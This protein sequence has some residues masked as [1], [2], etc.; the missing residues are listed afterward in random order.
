MNS[1]VAIVGLGDMG[2]LY[3]S[4][5][6]KS[7]YRVLGVDLP[8]RRAELEGF[9][10]KNQIEWVDSPQILAEEADL[11]L[12]F[13]E[14]SKFAVALKP[15]KSSF[16]RKDVILGGQSAIKTFETD[17]VKKIAGHKQRFVG[18]HSLHGPSVSPQGQIL[19][20]IPQNLSAAETKSIQ[21]I[22]NSLGS[23]ILKL[24]TPKVHDSLM[25][26]VQVASHLAFLS[27][28][29]AWKE[30]GCFPWS[31]GTYGSVVDQIKILM[32]LRIYSGKAHVYADLAMLNP[33]SK[34]Y[35][36]QFH[37]SCEE[38]LSLGLKKK[39]SALKNR[40]ESIRKKT[41]WNPRRTLILNDRALQ[42]SQVL[43]PESRIAPNSHLS[44]I[45]T[46][47]TWQKLRVDPYHHLLFQTPVFSMRLGIVE[48]FF[49]D[50]A[51]LTAASQSYAENPSVIEQDKAYVAAAH[52]WSKNILNMNR[53][54][55]LQE[56]ESVKDYFAS[57]LEQGLAKSTVL[58]ESLKK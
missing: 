30:S 21:N 54:A 6:R 3:S 48:R 46:A 18:L 57:Q 49:C 34:R 22:L 16:G 58:I 33:F 31:D 44:L 39:H 28:G 43:S 2:K 55:Y 25:A 32:M 50:E 19:L 9:L 24:A 35:V 11:I 4:H 45:A 40:I 17:I 20:M 7:G 26:D 8:H 12:F 23:K 5:L 53:K 27:M 47:D 15:F 51:L 10:N 29:S 1:T 14:S 41:K 52:R 13:V 56:F 37:K 42:R 38:I 36:R